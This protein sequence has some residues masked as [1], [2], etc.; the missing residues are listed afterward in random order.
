MDNLKRDLWYVL[1]NLQLAKVYIFVD[2]SFA[3]NKDLSSQIEFVLIIGTKSKGITEFTLIG[4]IIH[5]NLIKCK[6]VI[7]AMLT[8]ELYVII[9]RI[10]ILIMLSSIINII[11]NKLKIKQLL[12]V[13]YIDSFSLYECIVKLGITKKKCLIIDIMLIR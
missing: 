6:K 1:V 10:D 7:Y 2:E 3:N 5:T 9:A 4:N 8:L 13:I 12:T 11:I